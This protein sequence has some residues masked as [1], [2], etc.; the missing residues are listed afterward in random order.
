MAEQGFDMIIHPD[1]RTEV[2]VVGVQGPACLKES[3]E[4]H[5]L[6]GGEGE[7]R[8]TPDM[9]RRETPGQQIRGKAGGS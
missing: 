1:G 6:L 9:H 7:V 3:K 2:E 8:H 4:L 5:D